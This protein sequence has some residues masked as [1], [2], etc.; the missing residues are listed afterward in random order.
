M[1]SFKIAHK[2]IENNFNS[3]HI[4]INKILKKLFSIK[5]SS[6]KWKLIERH[7]VFENEKYVGTY[8]RIYKICIYFF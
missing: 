7:E 6:T 5:G 1:C 8:T 2:Y 3:I 4:K